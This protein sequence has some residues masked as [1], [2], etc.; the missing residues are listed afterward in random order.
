M[1]SEIIQVI[2]PYLTP[3]QSSYEQVIT[4]PILQPMIEFHNKYVVTPLLKSDHFATLLSTPQSNFITMAFVYL[5]IGLAIYE[6]IFHTGVYF[7]LWMNPAHEVFL[8]LP[9]HCAHVYLSLNVI[10][11]LDFPEGKTKVE[12]MDDLK[13][14]AKFL[15]RPI[16]YH[17]EFS[18]DEYADP[19]FGTNLKFLRGKVLKWFLQSQ[20]YYLNKPDFKDDIGIDDVLL[21]NKKG[22]LLDKEKEEEFLCNVEVQTG[23]TVYAIIRV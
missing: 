3:V 12:S 22:K 13:D 21:F 14:S 18:P 9:V 7:K 5:M 23:E 19:E 10:D 15:K 8:N 17:F 20:V 1:R 4:H 2:G 11:E 6:V 16:V